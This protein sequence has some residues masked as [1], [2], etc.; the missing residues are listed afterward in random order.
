LALADGLRQVTSQPVAADRPR[1]PPRSA[2]SGT[3]CPGS[4]AVPSLVPLPDLLAPLLRLSRASTASLALTSSWRLGVVRGQRGHGRGPVGRQAPR[5]RVEL[6]WRDAEPVGGRTRPRSARSAGTT[7]STRCPRR[8]MACTGPV[9]CWNR[10]ANLAHPAGRAAHRPD[11]AE[12]RGPEV[13]GQAAQP[14]LAAPAR[15]PSHRSPDLGL[16]GLGRELSRVHVRAVDGGKRQSTSVSTVRG[17]SSSLTSGDR[18]VSRRVSRV[19]S[20]A[21]DPLAISPLR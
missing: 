4:T 3:P 1:P 15:A 11:L 13:G 7:G 21:S 19:T 9:V 2:T 20:A 12:R 17:R 6:S 8:P 16:G 14:L 18:E 10:T 5:H